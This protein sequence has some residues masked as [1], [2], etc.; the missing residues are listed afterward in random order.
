MKKITVIIFI[1]TGLFSNKLEAQKIISNLDTLL[2]YSNL[3]TSVQTAKIRLNQSKKAKLAAIY[4]VLD[5]NSNASF[6]YTDN[7]KLPVNLFPAEIF[8]GQPG[9][10][11]EIR[12][13]I[14]YV[15]NANIYADIKLLNVQGWEDIKL[16][17]LNV[18]ATQSDNAISL[19]T[20]YQLY[21]L[22]SPI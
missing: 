7:T 20:L 21:L 16:S 8:G 13:G 5:P 22:N 19:K 9:T 17:K 12:S 2:N 14:Q 11:Q 6:S 1:L 3:K 4:G 15:S 10:Y 18:D